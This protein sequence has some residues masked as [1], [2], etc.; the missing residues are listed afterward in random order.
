MRLCIPVAT[1]VGLQARPFPHFGSA[2][3]FLLYNTDQRSFEAVQ[4]TNQHHQHGTCQPL[5]ALIGKQV[6]VIVCAGMGARAVQRLNAGG[7]RAFQ[8][9]AATAEEMIAQFQNGKLP[10][11]T[12]G[13]ACTDHQCH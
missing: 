11:I 6:D 9:A 3:Y 8:A 2:P 1:P 12:P 5:S 10:E 7:I 13:R 4:G